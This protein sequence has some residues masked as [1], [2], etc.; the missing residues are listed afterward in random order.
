MVETLVE[1]PGLL[2]QKPRN[3]R[4]FYSIS[5]ARSLPRSAGA[6]PFQI[7]L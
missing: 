3:A 5:N 2:C 4:L 1:L 6:G 7:G